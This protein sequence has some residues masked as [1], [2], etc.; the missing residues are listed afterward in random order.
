MF[1][2]S[3]FVD[4]VNVLLLCDG[5]SDNNSLHWNAILF[6]SPLQ[7][8]HS[9]ARTRR[10]KQPCVY[11]SNSV[12]SFHLELIGDLVFKLNPG[13]MGES[14]QVIVTTRHNNNRSA[15]QSNYAFRDTRNLSSTVNFSTGLSIYGCNLL[16][17]INIRNNESHYHPIPVRVSARQHGRV[18]QFKQCNHNNL[19]TISRSPMVPTFKPSKAIDFCLLNAKSIKNK[20]GLINDFVVEN[21]TDIMALTETWLLPGDA[22]ATVINDITPR[23]YIFKHV[24]RGGRG[25]GV[26]LMFK[27]HLSL[28]MKSSKKYKSFEHIDMLMKSSSKSLRIIIIYRPPPSKAN[29]SNSE[30][31]FSEFGK[32]LE[33]LVTDR[34]E[35]YS[36]RFQLSRR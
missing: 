9:R 23:G 36:W 21:N 32:L 6:N 30:L 5:C 10:Y 2:R 7:I 19:I 34:G 12:A 31:F 28:K 20:A 16:N 18:N 8:R 1:D 3:R 15:T 35:T 25:G 11:Y 14:I 24:P 22:D 33:Q 26:G 29:R 4:F 17:L 27:K 13:H